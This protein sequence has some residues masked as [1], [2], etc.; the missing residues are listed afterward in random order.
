MKVASALQWLASPFGKI[1]LKSSTYILTSF[2]TLQLLP[3]DAGSSWTSTMADEVGE[4]ETSI[5]LLFL[6]EKKNNNF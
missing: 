1:E 4:A 3:D 2:N 5:Q 6:D